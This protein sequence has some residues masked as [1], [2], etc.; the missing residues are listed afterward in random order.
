MKHLTGW[1]L[2][3][4][5]RAHPLRALMAIAAI[6]LGIALGFAIH[7]INTAAFNEF[8][9]AINSIA[10]KA[11]LQ[12]QSA[13]PLF[14]EAVFVRVAQ[15]EG[16]AVASPV[17]ELDAA[18]IGRNATLKILAS[19]VLR[20]AAIAPDLI[21]VPAADRPFD[22]FSDDAIF[23]SPAAMAWLQ[24]KPG[25]M[26]QLR[27]GTRD[28]A[29][30]VA[31]GLLQARAGQRI[32]VM[33][34]GTAQW[35]F[36]R[37]GQLS[38]IDLKLAAGVPRAA[39]RQQLEQALGAAFL[40]SETGDQ[41]QRSTNMSRAYRVNL[42][43]L[44]LVALFTGAFLVFSTQALSVLRRRSQFALLRV[45]GLTRRQLLVQIL[46]E[47]ALLGALG[48]LLGLLAGYAMAAAALHFFGGDLGGGYFPGVLPTLAFAPLAA[49][50]FFSLGTLVALL[51]SAAPALEAARARPAVALKSG[52]EDVALAR[53][54]TPW[55]GLLCLAAG[56]AFT[57]LPP[58]F[59]LPLFG[60]FAVALLLIGGISL[61]PR[62]C[63]L[64]F[65]AL[66]A[67]LRQP[68][69]LTMLALARLKNV[70]NQASIALGGILSSFSLMVAMAIMVA[71]FR[72]SVDDWL[73]QI[74]PADLYVRV[75][76]AGTTG[77]LNMV[78]Q[79][80]LAAN[81]RLLRVEYLRTV[82][83]TLAPERPAVTLIARPIDVLDPGKTLPLL[84]APIP[85]E[86]SAI[87]IWVSEA[88]VDIYGYAVGQTVRLPLGPQPFLVAGIWRDYARQSGSIQMRLDDYR[89]L[90]GDMTVTDAGIWLK[91][92]HATTEART[93]LHA[94]PFGRLLEFSEPG[95][96]RALSLKIFD[97]SFA[98]TYLL[99]LVAII[100]GLFGVAATF[101]AQTLARAKEFG[102][103]RH[104]GVTRRQV[105]AVLAL[106]GG[107][108]TSAGILLG[109]ALGACISLILVFIVNPQSFHWTM[110]LSIPWPL[111]AGVAALLLLS[112]TVTALVAGRYAVSGDAV[113]VVREDW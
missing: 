1:L 21:G 107:L 49:V 97:R 58:V 30:R 105:L 108:L 35:R 38:R 91:A 79:A 93:E 96:I 62:F 20:S 72:V 111:L 25:A 89:R 47:G 55:P 53:L 54:A 71:S 44:A 6:A 90:T 63:A 88:M 103:L 99:E 11:D 85:V 9:A 31:G 8:T 57:Q 40:V 106:E 2:R 56:A 10:G 104:I 4:E 69:T 67:L 100:I 15:H 75:A 39:F 83:I 13:Q 22:T 42:N 60:Y 61:M 29:L 82:P 18:V 70:P 51:G 16:V 12:L 27:A 109:F 41:E 78:E 43:V 74:L 80:L 26:I 34:L 23:L 46:G 14:D 110:Q 81:P 3:G 87:P 94:L 48:S 73:V 98:V 59:D 95:E 24:V 66:T 36:E 45:L 17:L 28:V 5:L 37:L 64:L 92:G 19:D 101:S 52:S 33:D 113:R 86:A 77:G 50:G 68:G 65:G 7:L 84:G 102:M 112:A 32:A 76:A